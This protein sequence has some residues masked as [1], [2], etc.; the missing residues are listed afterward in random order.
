MPQFYVPA[1]GAL[2]NDSNL[3]VNT[4]FPPTAAPGVL[5]ANGI[6]TVSPTPDPY[7]SNLYTTEP[8]F[9]IVGDYANESWVATPLPLPTAKENATVEAKTASNTAAADLITA[10]GVNV[11]IWTGA[12]SQDP[13][14]RPPIYNT[15][16]NE[17]A[18]IGDSLA[19]TL[20]AI[21]TATSVDEINNIIHPPTGIINTGRGSGL[22]PEDLN[23]SYYTEFNSVSMT[24][25]ETELYVPGTATVIPYDPGLPPPYIF[26]SSGDCFNPGNYVIQ[27]RVSATSEVIAEF[28]VPLNPLSQNVPF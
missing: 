6:Y 18:S 13:A 3:K 16:L 20:T 2:Y 8:A 10:S 11:D 4:G 7:D 23:P 28:V 21:D 24:E 14:S 12:A 22:G 26:D 27:I 5:A 15:L 17:M 25:A 1:S 19:S 9:T